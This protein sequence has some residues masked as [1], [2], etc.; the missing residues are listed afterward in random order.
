MEFTQNDWD[1]GGIINKI[2][3]LTKRGT[4]KIHAIILKNIRNIPQL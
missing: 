3:I 4:D 2:I 1:K